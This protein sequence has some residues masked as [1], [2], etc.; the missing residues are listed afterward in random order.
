MDDFAVQVGRWCDKAE[1]RAREA[2]IAIAWEALT[3]V[4]ELTPVR[5]GWLRSNWQAVTGDSDL[6]VERRE[7]VKSTTEI[8]AGLLAGTAGGIVGAAGGTALGG[9][10]GGIAGGLATSMAA[11]EGAEAFVRRLETPNLRAFTEARLGE[12]IRIVNPVRYARAIESGRQVE[13][14]DGSITQVPGRG[15][16]AQ[17]VAEMPVIA[18]RAVGR[19][20]RA[21]G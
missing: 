15:M 18:E 6:P 16:V 1:G 14:A 9:P 17:T 20:T 19:I 8:A 5:T 3:R 10:A 13:R 21:G 11:Q 7:G 2:F 12:T 4:K